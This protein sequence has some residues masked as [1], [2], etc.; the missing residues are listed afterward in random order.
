LMEN[1]EKEICHIC[2]T[3]LLLFVTKV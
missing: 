2:L 1:I 3:V